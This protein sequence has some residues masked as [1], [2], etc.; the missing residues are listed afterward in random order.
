[1]GSFDT[2]ITH[3]PNSTPGQETF[4]SAVILITDV[5]GYKLPNARLI[6]DTIAKEAG[7]L[8]V[9]PDLHEG[10]SLQ[11]EVLD[12]TVVSKTP[13]WGE[14]ITK[15]FNFVAALPTLLPWFSRHGDAKT[16]PLLLSFLS[17][18]KQ[19]YSIKYVGTIGYCWG[20]RY[21]FLLAGRDGLI[22]ACA[23]AHPSFVGVPNDIEDIKRPCLVLCAEEDGVF[24]ESSRVKTEEILKSKDFD[25]KVLLYP[26]TKHGFAVR[27]NEDNPVVLQA[28]DDALKETVE[29]FKKHLVKE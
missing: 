16:M 9:V 29:F 1:I 20:G 11:P 23:A 10:D 7:V 12:A 13:T 28:R 3:P 22:D 14:R 6:A 8:V 18:F 2:Y 21:S 26:G 15:T 27:G 4:T 24:P 17:T 19:A 25:S 5:F